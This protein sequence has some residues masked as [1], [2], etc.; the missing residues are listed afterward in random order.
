MKNTGLADGSLDIAVFSLS[1]M[2]KNWPDYIVEAK[3]C[4]STN[5]ILMI[6]ET[7]K[8]TKEGE[9]LSMLRDVVKTE[10]FEIYR[11]EEK[12]DFTFIEARKS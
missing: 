11:D 6:A 3:R 7:T 9:R 1:M 5:G 12:G 10:G 8:K 4:L 2:G